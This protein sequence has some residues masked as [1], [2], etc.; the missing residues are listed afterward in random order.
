M[1]SQGVWVQGHPETNVD[2]VLPEGKM[3]PS[4]EQGRTSNETT[5]N[6]IRLSDVCNNQL[7]SI[8]SL[9]AL[10]MGGLIAPAPLLLET[11]VKPAQTQSTTD[12]SNLFQPSWSFLISSIVGP[13]F[14]PQSLELLFY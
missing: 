13:Y 2:Q 3:A 11:C 14:F 6:E 4:T 12:N 5:G 8:A 1:V 9:L 10:R 7:L